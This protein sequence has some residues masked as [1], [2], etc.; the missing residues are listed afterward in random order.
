MSNDEIHVR[1]HVSRDLLQSAA[2]FKTDRQVV[3]EYVSN[4]LQYVEDGVRPRVTVTIDS[5]RRLI[6]IEDNGRGM[7][8]DGLQNFFVMHGENEDRKRG[9]HGRGRFGTGKSAAFGIADRLRVSSVRGRL[10]NTV[11]LTRAEIQQA[12]ESSIPVRP[13]ESN[14]RTNADN[15][16]II[17]VS[18]IRLSKL[19]Q[20]GIINFI[21]RHLAQ[22]PNKPQVIV[23]NHECEFHEPAVHR[24]VEIVP[25]DNQK[26]ILGDVVL[27]LKVSKVAL[28][29]EFQGVAIF[30]NGQWMETTLAGAHSQ[31]MSQ[32][33]FGEIDV[34]RLDTDDSPISAFDM[35]RS[36]QLNRSNPLVDTL[37][38]F[39]GWHVDQLRRQLVKQENERRAEEDQKRLAKEAS[40][41]A[42][43]IN[44]DFRDFSD[45]INRIQ[46]ARSGRGADTSALL[47][48]QV[49]NGDHAVPGG[50]QTATEDEPT[51]SP[52]HGNGNGGNGS[53]IP[54]LGS[55]LRITEDGDT[56]GTAAS[57]SSRSKSGGGFKVDFRAMGA[58]SPR[59]SYSSNE[60]CIFI[61]L[62]HP[63]I[64]AA[65]G[66]AKT[67]DL[68]FKRLAY[69]VAFAEYA[70]ALAQEMSEHGEYIEPFEPIVDVRD[71]LN[72][73]ARK[74]A[75][76]YA[77]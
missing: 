2:L 76:L 61:N 3:W 44:E 6:R 25:D 67:E 63:Q 62:E 7:D 51:G 33:I 17:E 36:M 54:S 65:K 26:R 47:N 41:I 23:N 39:I 11:E 69:E 38:H 5:R 48:Q 55:R 60:R 31:P 71:T 16:T 12:G 70:I 34:P 15:G 52:G 74:A 13:L 27:R 45:R 18:E 20:A 32:Y 58:E 66:T 42:D 4:A 75:A 50:D 1:S 73:M 59:A 22:W 40:K 9:R 24:M 29:P 14:V 43:I 30:S 57:L 68:N 37:L 77:V 10:R 56:Q 64:V 46:R 8:R 72:R 49:T 53:Q 21:E 19:D 28:E 35:S